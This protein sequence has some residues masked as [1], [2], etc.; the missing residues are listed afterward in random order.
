MRTIT[1]HPGYEREGGGGE[2]E[3]RRKE[4]GW[5]EASKRRRNSR[6]EIRGLSMRVGEGKRTKKSV[7]CVMRR[8]QL[9]GRGDVPILCCN[10]SLVTLGSVCYTFGGTPWGKYME[11]AAG[12]VVRN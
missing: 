5:G 12:R 2:R 4:G 10:F 3:R 6:G 7:L 11:G 1:S 9:R 8:E